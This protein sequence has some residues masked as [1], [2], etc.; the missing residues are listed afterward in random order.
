MKTIIH[1]AASRGHADYG[2]L[3]TNYSFSFSGY[4]NPER[5]HFGMLRV[6]ND[7]IVDPGMGFGTHP[8]ENMEIIT[9]P[10]SGSLQHKDSTGTSSIINANEVQVMSAGSGI[11]HSEFNPSNKEI[12]SLFQ[13]W[14]FPK[15]KNVAPR[16]GQNIFLENDRIN[17]WQL[18]VSPDKT[19]N[20]LWIYQD[21]FISRIKITKKKDVHY[22]PFINGNGMYLMA[23]EGNISI[24]GEKLETR[25][26]VGI[27]DTNEIHIKSE[28]IADLLMI[29]V[30]MN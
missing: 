12:V 30:P 5:I 10:L 13:I 21:A 16:Y 23:I 14:I 7:D 25:D 6:L 8:H 11:Q 19:N 27:S 24:N 17:Q 1:K 15:V 29:E 28:G 9:I 20:S 2:W 18:L 22:M 4:Y 3:K 26:A